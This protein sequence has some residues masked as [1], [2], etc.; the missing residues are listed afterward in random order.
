MFCCLFF[1]FKQKTA[2]EMRISDWSSDVC[3][4]D[5]EAAYPTQ[6]VARVPTRRTH[7]RAERNRYVGSKAQRRDTT[8]AREE[9]AG[10]S[11]RDRWGLRTESAHVERPLRN[12]GISMKR[13]RL[14]REGRRV[15]GGKSVRGRGERGGRG[16]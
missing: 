16:K 3:S 9:R 13:G 6:R 7:R 1:F 11:E 10:V 12:Q 14:R 2:Y 4:S 8:A 15:V 5:L